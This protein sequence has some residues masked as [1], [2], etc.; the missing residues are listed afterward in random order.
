M[1]SSISQVSVDTQGIYR[2]YY[3]SLLVD[4]FCSY[5]NFISP[6]DR[7]TYNWTE[8]AVANPPIVRML[9]CFYEA[10]N[11]MK[12]G[13][14]RRECVSNNTWRHP[15]DA[16]FSYDGA[17]CITNSTYQMRL[18]SRVSFKEL[19]CKPYTYT[20]LLTI[21]NFVFVL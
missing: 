11:L 12:G 9:D 2:S 8:T 13:M 15:D 21:V 7:G 1:D 17:Q 6:D 4:G 18:L 16:S 3:F 10:Q 19:I 14:A 5:E 20:H